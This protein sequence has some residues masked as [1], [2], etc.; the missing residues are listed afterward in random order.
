[1]EAGARETTRLLRFGMRTYAKA[2]DRIAALNLSLP[3]KQRLIA[4][5]E[6]RIALTRARSR[7]ALIASC[8]EGDFSFSYGRSV[9]TFL[10][11]S[12]T[13]PPACSSSSTCRDAVPARRRCAA[14]A[15][16]S[17]RAVR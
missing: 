17:G 1:V 13:R 8:S 14:T 6:R 16:R 4:W 2:L 5:A 11:T 9:D 3:E 10:A 7:A 12:S 15:C